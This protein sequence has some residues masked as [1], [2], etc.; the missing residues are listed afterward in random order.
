M[1]V[2]FRRDHEPSFAAQ[3]DEVTIGCNPVISAGRL[4]ECNRWQ[5]ADVSGGHALLICPHCKPDPNIDDVI[6]N[7]PT[8]IASLCAD[9]TPVKRVDAER[10]IAVAGLIGGGVSLAALISTLGIHPGLSPIANITPLAIKAGFAVSLA[11]VGFAAIINLFRPDGSP[12]NMLQ[13]AAVIFVIFASIALVQNGNIN[14]AGDAK[15]F[16]GATWQ[17][18]SLRIAALSVPIAAMISWAVRQ[19]APVQL[20]QAGA[21]VGMTA[22]AAA[23]AIYALACNENSSAFVVVWY[24]SGIAVPTAIGALLGPHFLRW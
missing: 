1:V 11:A 13:K 8:L 2:S 17:S 5:V 3:T 7:N 15:L 24:S 10:Q 4:L 19:Q 21:A 18:C 20:R 22:G 12:A 14:N 9:L 6:M 23:G 16:F